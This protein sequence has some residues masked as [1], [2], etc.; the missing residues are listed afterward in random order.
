[1]GVGLGYSPSKSLSPK[2]CEDGKTLGSRNPEAGSIAGLAG[3][4]H[5]E[6]D[7]YLDGGAGHLEDD[8]SMDGG[9]ASNRGLLA[10]IEDELR[11]NL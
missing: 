5:L 7:V 3:S 10:A 6:D 2:A 11:R 4:G 8:V 1:M 9:A